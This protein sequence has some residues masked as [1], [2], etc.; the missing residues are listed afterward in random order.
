MIEAETIY[1]YSY[2]DVHFRISAERGI[3]SEISE[4]F[5]F[6]IP[7]AHFN[8]KVR[9][10]LWDGRIR[11]FNLM[12]GELYLGLYP[13]LVSF[14]KERGYKIINANDDKSPVFLQ[15][16]T[17]KYVHWNITFSEFIK[18]LNIH[19]PNG[20]DLHEYQ[21]LAVSECID[22]PR[23]L[24]LS[25]TASGKSLIIYCLIRWSLIAA[26]RKILLVVPTTHLVEQMATDFG[27]YSTKNGWNVDSKVHKIYDGAS[28]NGVLTNRDQIKTPVVVSTWQSIYKMPRTWFEQFE[29]LF[30]DEAHQGKAECI[31]GIAE[32]MY[33]CPT[34]IGFT[35]TLDKTPCHKLVLEGLFGP[36]HVTATTKQ[37]MDQG[38]IAKLMVN[39][40]V[41][42]YSEADRKQ[43]KPF[44]SGKEKDFNAELDFVLQHPKRQ[45]FLRDFALSLKD[46][47]IMLFNFVEKH[48]VPMYDDLIKHAP[49]RPIYLIHGGIDTDEREEIRKIVETQSDAI[50][51]ASY[52]TFSVGVNIK[53]VFNLILTSPFKSMIRLL[54]SIGRGLRLYVDKD[55]LQLWDVIDNLSFK[56][57]TGKEVHNYLMKQAL[58]RIGIYNQEQFKMRFIK[59]DLEK[60]K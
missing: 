22:S 33:D 38:K 41:L 44:F 26:K 18:E 47:T 8:P 32:K 42:E 34:K 17:K 51:E 35:G 12:N 11:L 13:R 55:T 20:T 14:A 43:V 56:T 52:G 1:V 57:K 39:L 15:G 29:C 28:N 58:E 27:E 24:I 59:V 21:S 19:I 48:G 7:N 45:K 37:L 31:K 54:Q 49:K 9:A 4:Y 50:I 36:V 30:L 46:N 6:K 5:T 23:K 40:V 10:K 25:P 16:L 60:I 53:R 3:L 2:N